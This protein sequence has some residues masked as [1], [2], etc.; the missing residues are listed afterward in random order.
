M[1][2]SF[3]VPE[4]NLVTNHG[5]G[6][7]TEG[8]FR[9]LLLL[10]HEV[11]LNDPTAPVEIAFCTPEQWVWAS[12][13]SYKI[14]YMPW[15]STRLPAGWVQKFQECDEVWTTSPW[16]K[17]IFEKNGLAN[18]RVFEHGVYALGDYGWAR[19]RRVLDGPVKFLHM[20]EPAPRKGGQMTHDVFRETFGDR[21]DVQLT[22]K[23]H[24]YNTVQGEDSDNV[25][26]ITAE[27]D[28]KELISLVQSHDVLVY[29][30]YGEGFGLIPLQAM[31]SGMPV[32][33]TGAWAPYR[34]LL[35]PE[36]TLPSRLIPSPW[37]DVDPG[38]MYEPDAAALAEMMKQC[39][40]RE[41]YADISAKA[42]YN[43]FEVE[44]RFDWI[45][46]TMDAFAH[47]FNMFPEV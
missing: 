47:I 36:L 24:G 33:C 41:V 17:T 23:A 13:D 40:D 43:S 20:G 34:K 10:G 25:R 11:T 42:Y 4:Q 15:E 46:L 3:M 21:T 29:P 12:P 30:S 31:V 37:P 19:K 39:A 35:L 44:R 22:I 18:V 6:V 8:V 28:P 9:S 14:G 2:F 5:Y 7:A 16:C 27:L 32:I 1:R 45:P 38:N 26:L